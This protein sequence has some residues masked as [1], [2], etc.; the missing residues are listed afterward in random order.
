MLLVPR[1]DE[2][3]ASVGTSPRSPSALELPGGARATTLEGLHR[4]VAGSGPHRPR[5][6]P[7]GRGHRPPRPE[8][9]ATRRSATSSAS[10]APWSRRSSSCAAPTTASAPSCARSP[11]PG[12]L[13]DTAG[14]SPDLSLRAEARAARDARRH[15]SGSRRPSPSSASGWPSSRSASA[16]ATTSQSGAEKQQREYFLRKQ[17][18]SIRKELGEDDA[19]VVDE[20]RTKIEESGMPDE[21]R[22]QA[23]RELGRLERMG[24]GS[25]E[26]S[27][28]RTYLDW[29]VSVPWGERS[30]ELLDPVARPR[31]ARRRPRRPRG[32]QGADHR[33]HRRP[34][35]APR[36][37]DRGRGPRRR[38]DPHPDRPA[39]HRQDLDRRVDR[40]ARP[41]ASSS[42]CRSAA[43]A[44]RP[45][46]AATAA[47]TSAPCRAAWSARCA[48]PGR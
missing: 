1:H 14:Y 25:G 23:E 20:Y 5:R 44:T 24:E 31:G 3:F 43:S 13:A 33:V 46:S 26:S 37:R 9:A 6:H 41:A 29:L 48:T 2:E 38:R 16:S 17:M 42:A 12:A 18:E 8:R 4:G 15:A 19:S 47:P 35:A 36:A 27:M 32:R 10:T 34:Q 22:E 11:S 40:H 7:A 28:I 30:E 39:R 21:V 45:R